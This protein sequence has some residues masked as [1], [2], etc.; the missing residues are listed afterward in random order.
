RSPGFEPTASTSGTGS[1]RIGAATRPGPDVDAVG[2]NPGDRLG[3][4]RR[5]AVVGI[6]EDLDLQPVAVARVRADGVDIRHRQ[7]S[8]RGGYKAGALADGLQHARGE[9]VAIFDADFVPP[10]DF[11]RRTV[12][13]FTDPEVGFV[14]GRWGHLNG[15]ESWLTRLQVPAID[16]HFLVEQQA[17]GVAGHWFNF[18]G[19]AGVWRVAAIT[20]AGGWQGDTLTED[21]DLSYRAHLRGW[22]GVY[23]PDVVAPAELPGDPTAFRR[24]QHRWAR[25]SLECARKLLGPIWASPAALSTKVQATFHLLAYGVHL[26]LLLMV[27]TYPA[28][29]LATT[30]SGPTPWWHGAAVLP[31]VMSVAPVVFLV[32]G[33][34]AQGRRIRPTTL[35]A[36]V[37]Y[38]SGLM[39]NTGRAAFEILHRPNPVFERTAKRGGR[40]AAAGEAYPALGLDGG[41]EG[42]GHR[43]GRRRL[44]RIVLAEAGL[45]LYATATAWFAISRGSWGVAAYATLFAAG[46]AAVAVTTVAGVV[47]PRSGRRRRLVDRVPV[48]VAAPPS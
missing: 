47:A 38:G 2:S 42:S 3:D 39:V 24:Q 31:N 35:A 33:Q 45:A 44:D 5:A 7:R 41:A 19:T 13:H 30:G 6:V 16:G 4:H 46:L 12:G 10:P 29:V 23:R 25:G 22:C 43:P 34:R 15:D 36:T 17:R 27:L 26:L 9:L 37:V 21:L 40:P 8:H 1:G 18:N 14:Q 32:A 48:P 11:L 20:D 28:V